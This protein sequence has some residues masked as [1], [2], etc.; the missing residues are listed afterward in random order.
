[1]T[2]FKKKI[3]KQSARIQNTEFSIEETN[4]VKKYVK[5]V[6]HP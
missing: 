2:Q 4:M 1:M 6:Q 5:S 3:N